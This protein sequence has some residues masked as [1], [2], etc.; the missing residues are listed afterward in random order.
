ME[1]REWRIEFLGGLLRFVPGWNLLAAISYGHVEIVREEDGLA[2]RYGL[3]F[4]LLYVV[5]IGMMLFVA[6]AGAAQR[7]SLRGVIA[8]FA[9]GCLWLCGM[10][11]VSAK[12][13]F[14]RFI[15][16]CVQEA[17]KEIGDGDVP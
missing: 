3:S 16:R 12:A 6:A 17:C 13:R 10:N 11:V 7:E 5:V 1:V 9:L 2:I 4:S 8:F 14:A 15:H